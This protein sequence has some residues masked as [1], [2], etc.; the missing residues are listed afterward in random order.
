MALDIKAFALAGGTLWGLGVCFLGIIAMFGWGASLVTVLSSLY[1]GY[2]ASVLG[3][4]IGGLWGFAD[5]AVGC[6]LF[7]WLYN[8][9][10]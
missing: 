1:R 3:A 8:T 5:G 2:D 6:A 7:A 4:V 9:F 10:A